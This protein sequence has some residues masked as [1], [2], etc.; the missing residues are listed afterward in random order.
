MK[1][2]TRDTLASDQIRQWDPALEMQLDL[3]GVEEGELSL[4]I[5]TAS[6]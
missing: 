4:S 6:H 3:I 1:G 2:P 5:A